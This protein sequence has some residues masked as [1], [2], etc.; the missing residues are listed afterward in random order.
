MLYRSYNTAEDRNGVSSTSPP[1]SVLQSRLPQKVLSDRG[2]QFTSELMQ[3][4]C[5]LIST[6]QLFTTPYNPKCNGLCERM[7]GDL[8]SMLKK[9]YQERPH[10]WDR[11][12]QTVLF[13]YQEVPQA[14]TGFL[15]FEWMYR[16]QHVVRCKY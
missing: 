11:Y 4:V 14:S 12:L 6:R 13:A 2:I 1:G 16:R 10:D 7:N 9:M 8:K 3:K 15:P 5:R